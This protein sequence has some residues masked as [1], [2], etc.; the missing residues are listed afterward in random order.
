MHLLETYA[1]STG[2]KIKKPFIFKKIFPLPC[3]K[4]I[5]V[6]NSSGMTGKCYDYFQEVIDFLY[7]KLDKYG[8]KI[9]QIGSKDDKPLQKVINLQGQSNL[10]QTAFILDN[11]SLHLGNDSFSIHMCSAFNIPLVA[12]YSVS[13]PELA[14]P[15]WKNNNQICLTP[16]NWSPS[17]NPNEF[18]KR[19]NEIPIN[20]VISAVEKLLFNTQDIN[21]DIIHIGNRYSHYVLECLPKD[22]LAPQLFQNQHINIRFD[23]INEIKDED[24]NGLFN[25]LNIR[26]C[27]II[28]DKPLNLQA[29]L[30]FKDKIVN[31]FY[32][33]TKE[34]DMNFVNQLESFGGKVQF[35]F[36]INKS[37]KEILEQ[38]KFDLIDHLQV[39]EVIENK[40]PEISLENLKNCKYKSSKLLIGNNQVYLS[41]AAYLENKP[42]KDFTLDKYQDLKDIEN[43]KLFLEEDSEFCLLFK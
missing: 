16:E 25:N 18:P 8:Y 12:L 34:I 14:G 33:V 36:D 9:I 13:S 2:S 3:S 17:F 23:Y 37:N 30:Q 29:F 4:Y 41:K 24:Y 39:I 20:K 10:N 28:T 42:T 7:Q 27:S 11:S 32:N 1:L 38:R 40:A 19:V 31:I 6:Q 26:P 5:T 22:I 15:F 43:I 21:I 35:I